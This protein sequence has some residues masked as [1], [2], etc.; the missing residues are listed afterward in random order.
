MERF[1][2]LIQPP[3][4]S[5]SG[6]DTFRVVIFQDD[7][8]AKSIA[9]LK[10]LGEFELLSK[11]PIRQSDPRKLFVA[12]EELLASLT[13]RQAEAIVGAFERGYY[14]EPRAVTL[15]E[16]AQAAG[17]GRASLEGHL[18]KAENKIMRSMAPLAAVHMK[19]LTPASARGR[20]FRAA[21]P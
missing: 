9:A 14:N 10:K 4:I 17:L 13:R 1:G 16:V 7:Q 15:A 3:I 19:G 20:P 18:R 2:G 12:A 5:E 6:W 8:A 11:R 21:G